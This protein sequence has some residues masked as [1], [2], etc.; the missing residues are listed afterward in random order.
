M[1]DASSTRPLEDA[2]LPDDAPVAALPLSSRDGVA[3]I[4]AMADAPS[5]GALVGGPLVRTIASVALPAVASM[6]LMTIFSTADAYWVGRHIGPDGLA[7]VSTSLFWIWLLIACAE[8]VSVGLTSVASRRHGERRH[9]AAAEAVGNGVVL[10]L[11]LGTAAALLGHLAL[12]W[13]FAVMDTPSHVTELGRVYLGTY[14]IGAPPYFGFFAV[15]AAFRASG[16]TRTPFLLLLASVIGA[17]V[18]DPV[19]ILGL[20]HAPRLGIAGAAVATVFTR[21]VAFIFGITL[22]VRRKMIRFGPISAATM[23]AIARVGLPTAATGIFFS[24][25]YIL[26]TRTTSLFGTPALAALGVGHRVE[27]WTFTIGVGFGAATAAIVGQSLGAGEVDRAARAGWIATGLA[28]VIGVVGALLE[29]TYAPD[30]AALFTTD[31]AV[32][33]ESVRYLRIVAFST[34]FIGS[35]LVLE[36]ALGGAGNTL[37]PMLSS[38]TF[39]ALRIPLAAW[40]A[41][42]WGTD[43][44]WW[45]ISLTAICRGLAMM[46]LWRGGGWRSKKV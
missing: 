46:L 43:G 17:L 34:I 15:D 16:N 42:R 14:L 18:L 21:S 4:P 12:D 32:I 45:T 3:A 10:A 39:T 27:S 6:L 28:T 41:A 22:L 31:P 29:L 19:L 11:V 1:S 7:A 33:A 40:A 23:R 5:H 13:L 9:I 38:T 25:T 2:R 24:L 35:E 20:A 44:I 26:I 37:P 8:L 36:G 30:F